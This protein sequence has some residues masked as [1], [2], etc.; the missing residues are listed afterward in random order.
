MPRRSNSRPS[1]STSSSRRCRSIE[2]IDTAHAFKCQA[3]GDRDGSNEPAVLALTVMI[4]WTIRLILT[5]F[6]AY[7][8]MLYMSKADR[9]H[10]VTF[11]VAADLS[12]ALRELPNQTAF[13]ESALREALGKSCPVCGGRGRLPTPHLAI[14]DFRREHLPRL[15][16]ETARQLREVVRLAKRLLA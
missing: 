2:S 1:C 4:D 8:I 15:G 3:N 12:Q 7:S 16:R 14:S 13:V 11:R 5:E 10:R 9:K 6:R